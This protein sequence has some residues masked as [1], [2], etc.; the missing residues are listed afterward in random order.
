[1][2]K[3]ADIEPDLD[4]DEHEIESHIFR[5]LFQI[6]MTPIPI[7]MHKKADNQKLETDEMTQMYD[8]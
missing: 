4:Q 5:R 8:N 2:L 1:M 6:L 3:N 7:L